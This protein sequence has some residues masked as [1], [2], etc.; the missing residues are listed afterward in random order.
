MASSQVEILP[1]SPFGCVLR[2][3]NRRDGCRESNA[4][5]KRFKNLVRDHLHTCILVASDENSQLPN[6]IEEKINQSKTGNSNYNERDDFPASQWR[7]LSAKRAKEMTATTT[8]MTPTTTVAIERNSL[9][10]SNTP[11]TLPR[12]DSLARIQN[13]GASSLVQIWEK[14]LNHSNSMNQSSNSSASRSD[15]GL[16]RNENA[17]SIVE[18]EEPSRGCEAGDSVPDERFD[19][20]PVNDDSFADWQSEKTV[21]SGQPSP[22]LSRKSDAG[23][24]ERLRVADII[25]RLMAANKGQSTLSSSSGGGGGGGGN[26]NDHEQS[27]SPAR[28]QDRIPAF[29]QLLEHRNFS[30]RIRGRQAFADLLMQMEKDRHGELNRLRE[31]RAVSGFPQKGR[32]QVK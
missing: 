18:E 27:C 15:S 3:H 25:K 6:N 22:T 17:S 13:L 24:S 14:R 8:T 21:S 19:T 11:R 5:Q 32:I 23:E 9:S 30:P 29:D 7:P 2:D 16:S 12:S 20:G 28:E 26:D 4:F 1:S 10:N 31:R